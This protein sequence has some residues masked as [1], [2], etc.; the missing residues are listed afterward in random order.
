MLSCLYRPYNL[1][2]HLDEIAKSSPHRWCHVQCLVTGSK[3]VIEEVQ[4]YHVCVPS[5]PDGDAA[6]SERNAPPAQATAVLPG[7]RD[8][9]QIASAVPGGRG[10]YRKAR[11]FQAH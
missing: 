9:R 3:A 1:F 2:N 10:I 11:L 5:D 6:A 4:P 7:K 8:Y